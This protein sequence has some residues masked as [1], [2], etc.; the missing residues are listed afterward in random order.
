MKRLGIFS[1]VVVMMFAIAIIN[2]HLG[3]IRLAL[4]ETNLLLAKQRLDR[5]RCL[6]QL[7][8][9]SNHIIRLVLTPGAVRDEALAEPGFVLFLVKLVLVGILFL[10][11]GVLADFVALFVVLVVVFLILIAVVLVFGVGVLLVSRSR[12]RRQDTAAA[13]TSVTL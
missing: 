3:L 9:P 10:V 8:F 11:V 4:L 13:R 1:L 7:L 12:V 6:L 2:S 5:V